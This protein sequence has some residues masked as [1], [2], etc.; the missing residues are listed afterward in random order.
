MMLPSAADG[1]IPN[2][3]TYDAGAAWKKTD[4]TGKPHLAVK[5]DSPAFEAPIDCALVGPNKKGLYRLIWIR[6]NQD[7]E[8]A[9]QQAAA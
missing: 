1:S 7:E 9:K 8:A 3:N 6:K 2:P 4:E 5:L